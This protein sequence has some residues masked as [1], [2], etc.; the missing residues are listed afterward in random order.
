MRRLGL[1]ERTW[2]LL[3]LIFSALIGNFFER[4]Q[5]ALLLYLLFAYGVFTLCPVN[6]VW[7]S[8][9]VPVLVG[10][11]SQMGVSPT[12]APLA[13]LFAFGGNFL[14]PINPLNMY[15]YAYGYFK[16]GDMFKAGIVP[17]LVLIVFDAFW[18]P[19]IVGAW[20]L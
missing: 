20:G 16:F 9:F 4:G 2:F 5:I 6:G 15:S 8:L 1:A 17:A 12:V 7:E 13:I 14:L 10:F 3:A 18:T 11:C 19:F